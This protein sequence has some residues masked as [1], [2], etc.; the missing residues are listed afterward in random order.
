MWVVTLRDHS[1]SHHSSASCQVSKADY[2]TPEAAIAQAA[3]QLGII[4][5]YKDQ[6]NAWWEIY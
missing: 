3:K 2:P 4:A 1:G 5:I 6:V